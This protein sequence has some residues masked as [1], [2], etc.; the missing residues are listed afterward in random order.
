MR[1]IL[2]STHGQL[3]LGL[4]SPCARLLRLQLLAPAV[5][6]VLCGILAHRAEPGAKPCCL[7]RR[8]LI[9]H[10]LKP[11]QLSRAII[12]GTGDQ[13]TCSQDKGSLW[14]RD[15]AGSTPPDLHE[16]VLSLWGQLSLPCAQALLKH[17]HGG[18]AT[19]RDGH[20]RDSGRSGR[21]SSGR[22]F[23]RR[24]LCPAC[25]CL[26]LGP[27]PDAV[28]RPLRHA[29][30][31][32]LHLWVGGQPLEAALTQ[33]GPHLCNHC[34]AFC[35][36]AQLLW[37]HAGLQ[38]HLLQWGQGQQSCGVCDKGRLQSDS[39]A[40]RNAACQATVVRRTTNR[41]SRTNT[42]STGRMPWHPTSSV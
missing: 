12:A 18:S 13:P 1:H 14:L 32:C 4:C 6:G 38:V 37:A 34:C 21:G 7:V 15:V 29:L 22:R 40:E 20:R 16:A 19:G 5:P 31:A 41:L 8:Q 28:T 24:R 11:L 10:R 42:Q 35:P 30:N 23:Q 33:H 17:S 36:L 39:T 25:R 27:L 3:A 9:P 26:L 2:S